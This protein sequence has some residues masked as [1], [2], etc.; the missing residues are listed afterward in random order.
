MEE[1]PY[2]VPLSIKQSSGELSSFK[3]AS[4]KALNGK[5]QHVI[6]LGTPCSGAFPRQ[7]LD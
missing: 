1:P 6:D 3:S 5:S 2:K 7:S 4:R